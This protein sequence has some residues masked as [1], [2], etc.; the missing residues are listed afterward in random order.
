MLGKGI[1]ALAVLIVTLGQTQA[2]AV[3]ASDKVSITNPS[4]ANAFGSDLGNSINVDQ[5]VQI[6]ADVINNQE[7]PQ[8]I[9][10]LVQVVDQDGF[11]VSVG[12]VLGI[13]QNPKQMFN[14]SLPWT[15]KEAG[16]YTAEIFVWEEFPANPKILSDYNTIKINV[17]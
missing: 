15:P 5:Q 13:E 10:Y 1:I 17:S 2:S 8:K 3:D 12:W 9:A 7:V 4:L 16:K 11:V 14:H 6:S